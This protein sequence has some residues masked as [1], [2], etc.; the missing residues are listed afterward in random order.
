M[1]KTGFGV[2]DFGN[3]AFWQG[4]KKSLGPDPA[5]LNQE[6]AE[7]ELAKI[8]NAIEKTSEAIASGKVN[9]G[10]ALEPAQ[11]AFEK[12]YKTELEEHIQALKQTSST[13]S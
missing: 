9:M 1:Q 12:E 7:A 2:S 5:S 11:L 6:Q 4:I 3:Q 8:S 13:P 10:S